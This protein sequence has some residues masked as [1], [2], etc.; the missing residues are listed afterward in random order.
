MNIAGYAYVVE[1]P[2]TSIRGMMVTMPTMGI[3]LGSLYTV[4]LGYVLPWHYLS[5]VAAIPPILFLFTTFF[6]PESPSYLVIKGRRQQAIA[7]LKNLRGKY[8][9]V[10][11][12]VKE[13]ERMNSA[14]GGWKG[15][16]ERDILR[17]IGI[18]VMVFFLSQMSGNFVIM[19]YTTRI[20]QAT[21]AP[22]NPDAITAIIGVLRVGGTMVAVFLLDVLGR[23]YCLLI[24][25]AINATFLFVL[26]TFVYMAEA[27]GPEDETFSK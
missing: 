15:L 1:L 21:G 18:V 2:D 17:R 26:G 4:A 22:L 27:A 3:V 11:A 25:H 12:E 16:M 14:S 23:R 13:L 9:D 7:L 24:S 8:V 20:L 19:I 10:E 6:L 5:F